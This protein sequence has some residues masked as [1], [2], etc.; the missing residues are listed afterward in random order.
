MTLPNVEE[1]DRNSNTLY[2]IA[3]GCAVVGLLAMANGAWLVAPIPFAVCFMALRGVYH[4]A[5]VDRPNA[6][7]IVIQRAEYNRKCREQWDKEHAE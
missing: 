1:C 4:I 6:L 7:E 5:T 3:A 2:L